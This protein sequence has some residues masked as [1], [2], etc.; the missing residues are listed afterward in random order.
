MKL[1]ATLAAVLVEATGSVAPP[2]IAKA[3]TFLPPSESSPRREW[4]E[5]VTRP[6]AHGYTRSRL[7]WAQNPTKPKGGDALFACA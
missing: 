7:R 4:P 3:G 6:G 2:P 5:R 1:E